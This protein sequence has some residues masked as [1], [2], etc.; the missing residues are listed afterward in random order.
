MAISLNW[1][2]QCQTEGHQLMGR[3]GIVKSGGV[4]NGETC[5]VNVGGGGVC[6]FSKICRKL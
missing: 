4:M 1:I 6:S 5:R 3:T 2:S